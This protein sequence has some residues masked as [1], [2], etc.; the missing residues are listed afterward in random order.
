MPNSYLKISIVTPSFNQAEY[1]EETIL[2]VLDQNYPELEY[3]IIDGGSTDDSVDIIRR[4]ESKLTYWVSEMDNGQ[5]EAL[6]KGFRRCTGELVMWLNSDDVLM[7][8]SLFLINKLFHEH[9][10]AD[11]IHGKSELFGEHMKDKLVGENFN[12][13][14]DLEKYLACMSFPQPSSF[15]RRKLLQG[16]SIHQKLH[17][18]MDYHFYLQ[19]VLQNMQGVYV[20]FVL[21]KYRIHKASKSNSEL[22][23]AVDW[24]FVFSKLILSLPDSDFAMKVMKKAALF[25]D[26]PERFSVVR[27]IDKGTLKRAMLLHLEIQAHYHYSALR[28]NAVKRIIRTIWETDAHFYKERQLKFVKY[29]LLLPVF[30]IKCF[31]RFT[32]K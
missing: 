1:L 21:S 23:F 18:G 5:S 7:P 3:L 14:E 32:R 27:D 29:K 6:N 12:N 13:N 4:Y 9:P 10:S 24:S 17:Y 26:T 8:E 22:C 11:F 19:A 30:V 28:I 15:F 2:S 20:P 16:N 25:V 31:R